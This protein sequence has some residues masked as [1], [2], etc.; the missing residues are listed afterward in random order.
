MISF[1]YHSAV[2][3]ISHLN[4]DVAMKWDAGFSF[5]VVLRKTSI[6]HKYRWL[7][8]SNRLAENMP[9]G[10]KRQD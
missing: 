8:S 7:S 1:I 4:V 2:E 6:D 9:T 5:S 3:I 10:E